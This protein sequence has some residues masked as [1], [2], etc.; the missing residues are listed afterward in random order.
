MGFV[1]LLTIASSKF[2][3]ILERKDMNSL[4][5]LLLLQFL[6]GTLTIMLRSSCQT[7]R[8]SC[9]LNNYLLKMTNVTSVGNNYSVQ[10][11]SNKECFGA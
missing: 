6:S 10:T 9:Q 4:G 3:S 1:L 5:Q 7:G 2:L 11:D 8:I